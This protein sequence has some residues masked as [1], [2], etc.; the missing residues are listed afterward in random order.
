MAIVFSLLIFNPIPSN[1][2]HFHPI[3]EQGADREQ[4]WLRSRQRCDLDDIHRLATNAPVW[5]WRQQERCRHAK[6]VDSINIVKV[7]GEIEG[8]VRRYKVPTSTLDWIE[9][10]HKISC[11]DRSIIR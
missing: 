7:G 5:G 11:D 10:D 1:S 8:I 3:V 6:P 2:I 9:A 4:V